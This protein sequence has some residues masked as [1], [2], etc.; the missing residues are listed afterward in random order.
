[1]MVDDDDADDDADD[2]DGNDDDDDPGE[3]SA[4]HER[5][6]R[7]MCDC[8]YRCTR[9]CTGGLGRFGGGCR[10]VVRRL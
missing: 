10:K 4:L 9:H 7:A 8:T 3:P 5:E 2:D 6:E 1:M